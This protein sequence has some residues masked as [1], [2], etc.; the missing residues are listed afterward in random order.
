[1]PDGRLGDAIEGGFHIFGG[2]LCAVVE[3]HILAQEEGVGLA[4]LGDLP[5]MRQIRDDRLAAV[6]GVVPDQIVEH[7]S[8]WCRD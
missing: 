6:A 4:V 3:L 8:P 7:A 1:M 5:A 2:Q